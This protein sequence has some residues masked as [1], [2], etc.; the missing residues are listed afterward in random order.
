MIWVSSESIF[1]VL[2][3]ANN[4]ITFLLPLLVMIPQGWHPPFQGPPPIPQLWQAERWLLRKQLEQECEIWWR[5]QVDSVCAMWYWSKQMRMYVWWH[6]SLIQL[7]KPQTPVWSSLELMFQQWQ[8]N[9]AYFPQNQGILQPWLQ[10][11]HGSSHEVKNPH[12]KIHTCIQ[13]NHPVLNT[14]LPVHLITLWALQTWFLH[15]FSLFLRHELTVLKV[16]EGH[17]CKYARVNTSL[18]DGKSMSQQHKNVKGKE[19]QKE[20][21]RDKYIGII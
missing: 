5:K 16:T 6:V 8:I 1:R 13:Q 9:H 14:L 3:H 20:Q 15:I 10:A 11:K 19:I 7:H 2:S 18:G 12:S 4:A 17:I 21:K